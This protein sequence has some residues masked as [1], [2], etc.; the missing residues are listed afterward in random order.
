M[1]FIGI[2]IKIKATTITAKNKKGTGYRVHGAR[3]IYY[4]PVD[5]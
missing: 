3:S 4:V 1:L 5:A 2:G